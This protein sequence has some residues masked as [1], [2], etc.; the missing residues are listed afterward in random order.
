MWKENRFWSSKI[1]FH[2]QRDANCGLPNTAKIQKATMLDSRMGR[3]SSKGKLFFAFLDKSNNP[4]M[5]TS[6]LVVLGHEVT[7]I[8]CN[9]LFTFHFTWPKFPYKRK[10]SYR[11]SHN[12]SDEKR[13]MK[14]LKYVMSRAYIYKT[15][16]LKRCSFVLWVGSQTL[17]IWITM[18]PCGVI[19]EL[20]LY[21]RVLSPLKPTFKA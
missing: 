13:K 18:C 15:L 21:F 2:R 16:V 4:I 3:K 9:S 6:F 5:V 8:L 10:T 17:R 20:H 14:L 12:L 1:V 7:K 11:K 19:W